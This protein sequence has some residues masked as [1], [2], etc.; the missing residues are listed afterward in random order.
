MRRDTRKSRSY[1]LVFLGVLA[2]T[3]S[4]CELAASEGY[5]LVLTVPKSVWGSGETVKAT[6][7]FENNTA[8]AATIVR[9]WLPSGWKIQ[10]RFSLDGE[11]REEERSGGIIR[12]V[13]GESYS[14]RRQPEEY[15][16][17]ESNDSLKMKL[18]LT[19]WLRNQREE[20]PAGEYRVSVWYGYERSEEEAALPLLDKTIFSNE[21]VFSI[22]AK[23]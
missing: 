5:K 20:I 7:A 23:P 4:S 19:S 8:S 3:V 12:G 13:T 16:L 22:N 2:F 18:D 1:Q 17:V 15:V 14:A 21:V 6:L 11:R 10:R 9:T